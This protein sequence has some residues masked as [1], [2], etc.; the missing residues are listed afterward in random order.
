MKENQ[1]FCLDSKSC[2]KQ[3]LTH[4]KIS[5]LHRYSEPRL[6]LF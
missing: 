3:N 4:E 6:D 1:T 5:F 2:M